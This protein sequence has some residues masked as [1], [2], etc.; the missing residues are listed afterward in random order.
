M[1]WFSGSNLVN[2]EIFLESLFLKLRVT[3]LA[4]LKINFKVMSNL[5]VCLSFVKLATIRFGTL[6]IIKE[7][8][9]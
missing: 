9:A 6:Y 4:T 8:L 3:T 5:L 1:P 7:P 2:Q